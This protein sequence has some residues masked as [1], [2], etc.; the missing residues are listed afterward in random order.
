MLSASSNM[1]IGD[2]LS[3]KVFLAEFQFV[4]KKCMVILQIRLILRKVFS[5]LSAYAN[6]GI[7]DM[8]S[9]QIF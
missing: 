7:G 5:C 8:I 1:R 4:N 2:I 3:N 6:M 9:I